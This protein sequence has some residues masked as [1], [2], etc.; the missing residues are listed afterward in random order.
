[1]NCPAGATF[2]VLSAELS[3]GWEAILGV[4]NYSFSLLGEELL[5]QLLSCSEKH[6]SRWGILKASFCPIPLWKMGKPTLVPTSSAA[7]C[8][9]GFRRL[10]SAFTFQKP[11]IRGV[12]QLENK[13]PIK[14]CYSCLLKWSSSLLLAFYWFPLFPALLNAASVSML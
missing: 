14:R 5:P 10:L 4:F 8:S 11:S 2:A 1:M 12:L 9:W 13:K 7:L 6:E 3:G